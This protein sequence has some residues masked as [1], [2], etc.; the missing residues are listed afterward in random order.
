MHAVGFKAKDASLQCLQV[1]GVEAG[2]TCS[3]I[4]QKLNTTFDIFLSINPNINCDSIFVGQ[5]VCTEAAA[6]R[7]GKEKRLMEYS[8]KKKSEECPQETTN[9]NKK[10]IT[11]EEGSSSA[12]S[13]CPLQM[14]HQMLALHH[15]QNPKILCRK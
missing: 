5:W 13:S 9:T 8:V 2:D 3:L 10:K 1:Y 6:D 12:T 11:G 15:A 4:V 7:R 14:P